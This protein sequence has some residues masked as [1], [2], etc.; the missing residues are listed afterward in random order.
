MKIEAPSDEDM[1]KIEARTKARL[2]WP[3]YFY[4]I[5]YWNRCH[6]NNSMLPVRGLGN[7]EYINK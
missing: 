3:V 4:F 5:S 1:M 2:G 6:T 7:K